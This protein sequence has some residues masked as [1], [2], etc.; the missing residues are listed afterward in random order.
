MEASGRALPHCLL[1]ELRRSAEVA[2]D[3]DNR[4]EKEKGRISKANKGNKN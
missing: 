4:R 3:D 1:A 2:A